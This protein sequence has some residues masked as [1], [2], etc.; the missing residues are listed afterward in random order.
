MFTKEG[1]VTKTSGTRAWVKTTKSKSCDACEAKDSCSEHTKV[2][3]TT[4]QVENSLNASSG[5]RVVVGFRTK[6]LLKITFILYIF[7]IILLIAGA[8]TGESISTR[9]NTDIS[10]TSLIV[11]VLFFTIALFIIRYINNLWANKKE[12]QPFLI[13]L[14][15]KESSIFCTSS[16]KMAL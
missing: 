12:F 9:L 4:I 7:P 16:N 2:Q 14:T 11:G 3:E 1:V 13:R 8:A 6:P 5:D 15:Q 10:L